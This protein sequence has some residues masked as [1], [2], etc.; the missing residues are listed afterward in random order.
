MTARRMATVDDHHM[1][2][3]FGHQSVGESHPHRAGTDD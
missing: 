1:R 3:G 2:V